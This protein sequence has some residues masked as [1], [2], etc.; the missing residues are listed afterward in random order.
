MALSSLSLP[1]ATRPNEDRSAREYS[2]DAAVIALPKHCY[3]CGCRI[4]AVVGALVG[5]PRAQLSFVFVDVIAADLIEQLDT[6][7]LAPLC[8]GPI[9]TRRSRMRPEGYL[10][11]ACIYCDAIQ[12]SAPLLDELIEFEAEGGD[13][14]VLPIVAIVSL[15]DAVL[16]LAEEL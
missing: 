2:V 3:R 10:A 15:P 14:A 13:I 7:D 12:G 6:R 1:T 8:V 9:R 11:N 5:P 16:S 4:M